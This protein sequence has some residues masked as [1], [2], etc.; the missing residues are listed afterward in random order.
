MTWRQPAGAFVSSAIIVTLSTHG[1]ASSEET[2]RIAFQNGV[3]NDWA[4]GVERGVHFGVR[5]AAHTGAL[6]GRGIELVAPSSA[7]HVPVIGVGRETVFI[8]VNRDAACQFDVVPSAARRKRAVTDWMARNGAIDTAE[9]DSLDAVPWH[10]HL[11]RF[12]ASELNERFTRA[13]GKPM[14]ASEWSGWVAVKAL[15]EAF[16]RRSPESSLCKSLQSVR[17]D[18]HKGRPIRFDSSERELRQT[19]VIVRD[20]KIVGEV[21]PWSEAKQ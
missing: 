19:L 6:L 16:F 21:D 3:A 12:G 5:E 4:A 13:T 9:A 15:A 18:A 8:R 20:G 2:L 1:A 17:I 14:T 11:A 7:G 10:P